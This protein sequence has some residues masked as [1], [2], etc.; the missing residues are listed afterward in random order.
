[1]KL[2]P[3]SLAYI[4]N[5]IE[6][7]AL[8]KIDKLIIG[9]GTIRG[10][11]E[12]R[13]ALMVQNKDIPTF[14][15]GTIGLNRLDVFKSRYEIARSADNLEVEVITDDKG[16]FAR[17]L[18]FK[19]KGV[20][21]DYR[22]ANPALLQDH[23]PKHISDPIAH[24]IK[25]NPDAVVMLWKGVAAMK[26]DT[27]E[28]VN[29]GNG[30]TLKIEDTIHRDVFT[31]EFATRGDVETVD[32]KAKTFAYTYPI[33]NLMT[34]LKQNPDGY[35]FITER[36]GICKMVVNGLDLYIPKRTE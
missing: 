20:K 34:L 35:M 29:D 33:K 23:T 1:M 11:D 8:V 13:T 7:A 30:I 18:M 14:E 9:D 21:I 6:T 4:L 2:D 19:G 12:D 32:G 3:H 17:A 24:T 15:F 25:I 28:F 36:H 10:S 22:A 31:Y 27:V 26:A 16:Q 5:V